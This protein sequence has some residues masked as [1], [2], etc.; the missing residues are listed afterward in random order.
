VICDSLRVTALVDDALDA[1][2]RA[3][4]EGHL[5]GCEACRAQAADER[6]I[7]AGLRALPAP[8]LPF[9]LEQRVRRQLRGRGRLSG[10]VRLVLP[11]AAILVVA[12]WVR[13]YAPFVAWELS[14]DHEHCF[15]MER[16]PAEVWG[17]E[18]EIVTGW[19]GERG[20]RLPLLP[21]SVGRLA[22]VGGRFC[23]LPD[24]SRLAHLYYASDE[25]Q[26]SVF[27]VPHAVRMRD[28]YTTSAGGNA[29]TLMRLGRTVVGVVGENEEEVN[30]FVSRLRTNVAG[31]F[32][33][34]PFVQ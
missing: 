33:D 16:L 20:E 27:A 12:L 11:L 13:G 32:I 28:E 17:S 30:V 3:E 14:R 7:R 34:P 5:A 25:G 26:V 6:Q 9:G 23:W 10:A 24:A 21:P 29:V 19:F 31:L 2:D 1:E 22:L 18:P 8:E 4:V 15:G